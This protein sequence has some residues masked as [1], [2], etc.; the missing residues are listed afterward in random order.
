MESRLCHLAI[1]ALFPRFCVSCKRE[2]SLMCP[3]CLEFWT[4]VPPQ[5]SCPFCAREGSFRTCT[6]CRHDVYLDGLSY[7]V[8]YGNAIFR[9]LLR[10]W[11]YHGDRSVEEIFLRSLRRAAPRMGPP[12]APYWVTHVPLHVTRERLRGFDQASQVAAWAREIFGL[13][14]EA[15]VRRV[16]K[17]KPRVQKSHE[18][19]RVGEMDGMFELIDGVHVPEHI[20]L[21]DDVFTSGSTIDAVARLLKEKGAV[22]VWGFTLAKGT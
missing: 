2:G 3:S 22:S 1:E 17:T 19:R 21:C 8:P 15:L 12:L 6:S 20:L 10:S 14:T 5:A 7:F 9:E 4:P 18:Q 11:K 16:H 13:P